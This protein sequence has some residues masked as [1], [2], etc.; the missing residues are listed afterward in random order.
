MDYETATSHTLSVVVTDDGATPLAITVVVN[1]LVQNVND[2]PPV[3][4]GPYDVS[5]AEGV[6]VGTSVADVSASDP[7][8]AVGAFGDP[9]H[10]IL[11][12][13]ANGR[14]NIDA[15]TGRV[16]TRAALDAEAATVY[17]LVIKAL[18]LGG[19]A[20]AT[21]TLTVTVTD[22]NDVAPS[23]TVGTFAETVPETSAGGYTALTLT[24]TDGDVTVAPLTY[25]VSSGDTSKF[26]MAGNLLK[27]AAQL[28]FESGTTQYPLTITVS[29]GTNTVDV[30]GSVTV[31]PANGAPPVFSLGE[32]HL[33]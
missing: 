6:A 18:E 10:S 15:S 12:G 7:D 14:F 30:V 9:Q 8:G 17:N 23:C 16:T 13:D 32:C 20:S 2:G 27:L 1:G 22:V 24:C 11:T 29:D 26:T 25:A 21:V 28:D 19:A 31:G 5:K 3:F 4:G 33:L